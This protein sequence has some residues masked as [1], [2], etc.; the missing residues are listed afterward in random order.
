MDRALR[1][2]EARV[3]QLML[4]IKYFY[5]TPLH[6][7]INVVAYTWTY[8]LYIVTIIVSGDF[9]ANGRN[10]PELQVAIAIVVLIVNILNI[11]YLIQLC[12]GTLKRIGAH[13][14]WKKPFDCTS[15]AVAV[16][17]ILQSCNANFRMNSH[18]QVA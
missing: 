14:G 15:Y 18:M 1:G 12:F 4:Y 8:L 7:I 2:N 6:Y 13:L 3:K 9:L 10:E 17:T 16:N 5:R 11:F